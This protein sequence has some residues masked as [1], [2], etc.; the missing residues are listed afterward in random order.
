MDSVNQHI[1]QMIKK[2]RGYRDMSQLDLAE[3]IETSQPYIASIESGRQE[4]SIKQLR[5]IAGVLNCTIDI[6]LTPIQE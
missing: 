5:K 2:I 1:G 4:V 6:R 3:K